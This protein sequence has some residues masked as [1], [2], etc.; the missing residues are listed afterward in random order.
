MNIVVFGA[1]GDVGRRVV[2]E[3]LARQHEV[4]GVVRR[5]S[6]REAMQEGVTP[7]LLDIADPDGVAA[8]LKAHDLAISAVRPPDGRE[9]ELVA[10]T[11]TVLLAA[12]QTGTRV[13]VVGGAASLKLPGDEKTTLFDS[14]NIPQ[15]VMPIARACLAQWDTCQSEKRADWAYLCPPASLV[16]GVRTGQ[17][18]RGGDILLTDETGKSEISLEDFA[19]ALLD[20]AE[21]P[22]HSR[23]LFTVAY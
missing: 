14:G 23:Q 1:A 2:R 18:R 6:Q 16:P 20:E 10:L 9:E 15:A 3:A 22:Q 5:P 8:L 21:Q 11:R 7:A 17:F 19:V 13:L 4:T 12:G